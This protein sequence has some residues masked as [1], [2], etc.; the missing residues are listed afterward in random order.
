MVQIVPEAPPM[1]HA[2]VESWR[3]LIGDGGSSV[4][5][6]IKTLGPVL[7]APISVYMAVVS[8]Q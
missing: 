4:P 5:H 1:Q 6:K 2:C 7:T 8:H 3:F